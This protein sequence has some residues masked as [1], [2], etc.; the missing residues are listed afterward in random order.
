[1]EL[2]FTVMCICCAALFAVGANSETAPPLCNRNATNATNGTDND[3]IDSHSPASI[4]KKLLDGYNDIDRLTRPNAGGKVDVISISLNVETLHSI[5]EGRM[6]YSMTVYYRQYWNDPRLRFDNS[7]VESLVIDGVIKDRIWLPDSFFVNAKDEILHDS[8]KQNSY[9]RVH[10]NGDVLSSY[11]MTL[12]LTCQ[13]ELDLFP[14]DTQYCFMRIESYGFTAADLIV[15]W[16]ESKPVTI[17]YQKLKLP[18]YYLRNHT[19]NEGI[20]D[21][22]TGSFSHVNL[23]LIFDRQLGFYI[24]LAYIPS[25]ALV[26]LSW[27]TLWIEA[28][29]SPARTTLGITTALALVTQSTWLRGQIPKVTYSTAIDIWMTMCECLVF[30]ILIEFVF[31]YHLYKLEERRKPNHLPL[32]YSE[33]LYNREDRGSLGDLK[34]PRGSAWNISSSLDKSDRASLYL[35]REN[36]WM[37]KE[38]AVPVTPKPRAKTDRKRLIRKE[39]QSLKFTVSDYRRLGLTVDQF[40]RPLFFLVFL[41]FNIYYWATFINME[42]ATKDWV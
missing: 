27:L 15:K 31:V 10:Y 35:S 11:R 39:D 33:R 13:M 4:L 20:V 29:S 41:S 42:S 2:I 17:E 14:F 6:D 30:T 9:V 26:I 22:S 28:T 18:Q 21:Y 19:I 25:G 23:T 16:Y 1:M 32:F 36:L 40:C 8:P 34:V 24:L 12:I 3:E 5:S 7:T 38:T 37:P